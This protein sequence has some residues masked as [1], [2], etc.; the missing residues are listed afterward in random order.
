MN[1]RRNSAKRGFGA[2][3]AHYAV[4]EAFG[5]QN[6]A[7]RE[8]LAGPSPGLPCGIVPLTASAPVSL[9]STLG[10][11]GGSPGP[12]HPFA[13]SGTIIRPSLS[14]GAPEVRL[15]RAAAIASRRQFGTTGLA[16]LSWSP[17]EQCSAQCLWAAA[18]RG[19]GDADR[20]NRK[21]TAARNACK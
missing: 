8:R 1:M 4:S 21:K 15:A 5:G 18:D 2:R 6:S 7:T 19:V 14:R 3:C 10:C 11:G 20:M 12:S 17:A 16:S 13:G 9:Q